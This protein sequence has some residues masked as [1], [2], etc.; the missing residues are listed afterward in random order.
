[1][2]LEKINQYFKPIIVLLTIL[3]LLYV[4]MT[5]LPEE[6][7]LLA[8][9]DKS[10]NQLLQLIE[11]YQKPDLIDKRINGLAYWKVGIVIKDIPDKNIYSKYS[12]E[13]SDESLTKILSEYSNVSYDKI[14]KIITIRNNDILENEKD[15][16]AIKKDI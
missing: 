6:N 4:M 8:W 5:R 13:I 1:M 2:L 11:T 14:S 12:L 3:I 7:Q 9:S 10:K 16:E 15:L